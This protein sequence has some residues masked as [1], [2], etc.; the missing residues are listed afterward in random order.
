MRR[1]RIATPW[2]P[3]LEGLEDPDSPHGGRVWA[4]LPDRTREQALVVLARL[5]A[6]GVVDDANGDG[7]EGDR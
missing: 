7:P 5:I 2:Q 4:T 6:R 3:T 1:L